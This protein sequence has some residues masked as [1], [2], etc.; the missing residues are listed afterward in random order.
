MAQ[1][2]DRRLRLKV[3]QHGTST[4]VHV[5]GSAGM[6]EAATLRLQLEELTGK[7]VPRIILD[8]SEMSFISSEGLAAIILGHIRCRHFDGEIRL[9]NPQLP[10]M[11]VLETTRLSTL[12]NIYP[13]VQQ[14]LVV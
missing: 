5:S 4:V 9:A 8:L 10:I 11:R 12:F 6:H 1:E 7:K 2:L 13:S 14:A 3:E